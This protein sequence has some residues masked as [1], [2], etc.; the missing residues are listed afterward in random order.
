[1]SHGVENRN[2]HLL[3]I[4]RCVEV[5][6]IYRSERVLWDGLMRKHHYL[7]LRSLV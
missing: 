7:G 2:K 6:P 4:L 5:R 3:R 1:M